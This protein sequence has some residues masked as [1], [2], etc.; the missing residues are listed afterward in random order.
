MT[1]EA[2]SKTATGRAWMCLVCGFVY[3]EDEGLPAEGIPPGTPWDAVPDDWCCPDC[4]VG[5]DDFVM[6]PV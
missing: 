6:S 3:Y 1:F 4:G 2:A 5:K